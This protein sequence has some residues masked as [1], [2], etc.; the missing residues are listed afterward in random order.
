MKVPEWGLSTQDPS[1]SL[2][3]QRN[4]IEVMPKYCNLPFVLQKKQQF[5]PN[6]K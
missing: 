4:V 5:K 1:P 6:L 3:N 2:E